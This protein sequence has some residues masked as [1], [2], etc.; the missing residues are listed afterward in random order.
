MPLAD[1]LLNWSMT[2]MFQLSKR[3]DLN[4]GVL[5]LT[6][7]QNG[8]NCNELFVMFPDQ[9]SCASLQIKKFN[10]AYCRLR[11]PNKAYSKIEKNQVTQRTSPCH[12]SN[13]MQHPPVYEDKK[14]VLNADSWLQNLMAKSPLKKI[15]CK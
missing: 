9:V 4:R 15:N 10:W 11:K 1:I 12:R 6:Y 7:T 5:T 13:Y 8:I 14:R 3:L 2:E